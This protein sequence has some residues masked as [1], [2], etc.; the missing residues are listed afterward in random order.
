[1]KPSV[2]SLVLSGI[3]LADLASTI[4]LVSYRGAEEGNPLMSYYLQQGIGAFVVAKLVLFVIP[5]GIAEWARTHRPKFVRQTLRFAIAAYLLAY[6]SVFWQVNSDRA[7]Q[8]TFTNARQVVSAS[9]FPG[10]RR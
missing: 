1:M 10:D 3:C 8:F 9:L 2:E 6:V 7:S 4:F 5:L